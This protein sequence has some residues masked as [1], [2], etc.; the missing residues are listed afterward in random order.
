MNATPLVT[1]WRL[2][3]GWRQYGRLLLVRCGR[4]AGGSPDDRIHTNEQ[5][6]GNAGVDD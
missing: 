4:V 1:V 3:A 5:R 2:I 6:T